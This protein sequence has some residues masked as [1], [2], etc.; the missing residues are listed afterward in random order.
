MKLNCQKTVDNYLLN[1]NPLYSF[2]FPISIL[3]AIIVFGI[4]KAYKISDN[5]YIIQ[6]IV[7]ILTLIAVMLLLDFI[8]H[9]MINQSDKR[10]LI[11]K[12]EVWIKDHNISSNEF[13]DIDLALNYEKAKENFVSKKEYKIENE[14]NEENEENNENFVSKQENEI[15]NED[16]EDNEETFNSHIEGFDINMKGDI[17][18]FPIDNNEYFSSPEK[19][20][21]PIP[22]PTWIPLSAEQVQQRLKN[23][24]YTAPRCKIY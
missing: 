13:L 4:F 1:M 12:C 21:Q 7:P 8:S 24:D 20:V 14:E 17:K 5:S 10:K 15:E 9:L 18:P 2:S 19:L 23:N 11:E 16:N 22:G 6:I 3:V